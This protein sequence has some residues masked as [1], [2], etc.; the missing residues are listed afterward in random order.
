MGERRGRA[1]DA[2]RDARRSHTSPPP[3]GTGGRRARR[4][5]ADA[6]PDRR[7]RPAAA[8]P[9]EQAD[10][11]RAR[12]LGRDRQGPRRR[13]AARARRQL[14]H[15]GGP[16]RE[17]DAEPGS[18][19]AMAR[20]TVRTERGRRGTPA[21]RR[22]ARAR[23]AMATRRS[24]ASLLLRD[25]VRGTFAFNRTSLAGHAVGA[26]IVEMIF[27]GVAPRSLLHR[28]GRSASR[29]SGCCAPGWPCAS[30]SASRATSAPG[31]SRACA[32]GRPA[33]SPRAR[34]GASRRGSSLPTAA[35][36]HQ[37]ALVLV[38]YTFCVACVPILAPQFRL[39]VSSSSWSSRPA[40]ARVAVAG[41]R[42]S[43]GSSRS[44]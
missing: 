17:P 25:H 30:P 11:A 43:A 19:R 27:A 6:A 7:A 4:V 9:V 35:A 20:A 31:S 13:R 1:A 26:I 33:S 37:L 21:R 10:R 5:Q 39:F 12:P 29:S 24:T 41:R 42:R 14:A 22:P 23:R 2:G 28:L 3:H 44:S 15:P 16:R 8:R 34:S 38:V 32:P 36:P 40:I 18:D